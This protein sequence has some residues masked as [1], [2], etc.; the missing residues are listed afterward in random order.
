MHFISMVFLLGLLP[1][2]L[3]DISRQHFDATIPNFFE[4]SRLN[5]SALF[6]DYNEPQSKASNRER[7][8]TG[9]PPVPA[10]NDLWE[11][12][13]CKGRKFMAQMSYSDYDVG[14]M[15]PVPQNTAQ[16]TWYFGK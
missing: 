7:R 14:Q 2:V 15:L 3:S 6:A 5:I 8:W 13:K 16:S 12:A 9:A 1:L 11:K 10:S 4:L